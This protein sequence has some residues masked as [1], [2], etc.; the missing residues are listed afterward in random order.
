MAN[1]T[2]KGKKLVKYQKIASAMPQLTAIHPTQLNFDTV[3]GAVPKSFSRNVSTQ[4]DSWS[5]VE[6]PLVANL[7]L[8]YIPEGHRECLRLI[9][10]QFD[11]MGDGHLRETNVTFHLTNLKPNG[12][13][14]TQRTYRKGPKDR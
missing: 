5:E 14:V 10:N 8:N 11:K 4:S 3:L 13:L 7:D 1:M 12:R 6:K 2:S 9:L